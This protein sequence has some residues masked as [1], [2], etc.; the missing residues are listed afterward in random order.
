VAS[1]PVALL[2][3]NRPDTTA[4]VFAAIRRRQP[5]RLL[6]VAD[7][8]R[9]DRPGE[10]ERCNEARRIALAVDWPCQVETCF[11]ERNMGCR[12]RI[13]SGIDWVF[14]RSPVAIILEDD[15]LPHVDFFPYCEQ[16]LERYADDQR[17]GLVSGTNFQ[18][19][20]H[21][22]DASYYY[23]RYIH[24]WGWASWARAWRH[25]DLGMKAWPELRS[26]GWLKRNVED[27][28]EAEHWQDAFDRVYH[29]KLDT[30]DFQWVFACWLNGMVGI[31]PAVNLISNIGFRADATHTTTT[32]SDLAAIPGEGLGLPLHHPDISAVDQAADA[33]VRRRFFLPPLRTRLRRRL[34][35]WLGRG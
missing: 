10:K 35:R 3:F 6:V 18:G 24:I 2:I 7:G 8:P 12:L 27:P 4:E 28:A 16:L 14:S 9:A 33:V 1:P 21:P 11:A 19:R 15:C 32:Q 17:V 25:Y 29:G 13:T 30:W 31:Q 34:E 23:S 22:V 20:R 26:N 5:E